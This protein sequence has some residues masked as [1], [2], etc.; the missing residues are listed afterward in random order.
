VPYTVQINLDEA[1][2]F[3][4]MS[5]IDEWLQ[6]RGLS[7]D[8]RQTR[9][10]LRRVYLRLDFPALGEANDFTNYFSEATLIV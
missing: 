5:E 2:L 8:V 7:P 9:M 4:R 3:G 1:N 10:T 6:G